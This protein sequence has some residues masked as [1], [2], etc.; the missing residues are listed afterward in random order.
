MLEAGAELTITTDYG[1]K[2]NAGLISMSYKKLAEVG[3][4]GGLCRG[5]GKRRVAG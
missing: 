2:G 5:W 1:I 4:G 3:G